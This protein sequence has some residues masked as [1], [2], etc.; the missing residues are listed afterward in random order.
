MSNNRGSLLLEA[1]ISITLLS[2]ILISV[3]SAVLASIR[4]TALAGNITQA[5]AL[6]QEGIEG[7]KAILTNKWQDIYKPLG[8]GNKGNLFPYHPI[9]SSGYWNLAS[10]SESITLGN[11]NYIREIF[12]YDVFRN[13]R[14]GVG[15]IVENAIVQ[16][17][18]QN[19]WEDPSTQMVT[20]KI[21]FPHGSPIY[22]SQYFSRWQNVIFTQNDWSGG[23]GQANWADQS[24]F[25]IENQTDTATA[26]EI[27]LK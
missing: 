26:N 4:S 17:P 15:A 2:V 24:K 6:A 12:I 8:T 19:I 13:Q 20:V 14:G 16:D 18:K 22:L 11:L 1:L 25:Y 7:T 27:K 21:T 5:T 23:S 3:S 9:I 10:G